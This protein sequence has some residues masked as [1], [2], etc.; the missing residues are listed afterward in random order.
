MITR[1]T[2]GL[3]TRT[4][5]IALPV[6]STT[7]SSSFLKLRPNPSSPERVISTRP[8][9]RSRPASQK[10][11]SAKVRWMSMPITRCI[12]CSS[13]LWVDGSSGPHDNYGSALTAQP[14][15]SQGRPATNT[16]SRLIVQIG[17]PTDVL[18]VPLVPDGHT[19]RQ[20][21]SCPSRMSGHRDPHTGYQPHRKL[22]CDGAPPN[23][24]LQRMS[25]EPDRARHDLQAR[26]GR[27]EKLASPRWPQPVAENNSRCKVHRRN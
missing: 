15:R 9:D 7:T 3:S 23:G 24:A 13:L 1:A 18:P 27:R 2:Y 19:I 5:A 22:V 10:T 16:S 20:D 21:Q 12:S 6:A 26:R 11:T 17:L 8:P 14:G 25:L 4:T